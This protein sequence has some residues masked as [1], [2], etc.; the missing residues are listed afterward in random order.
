MLAE[1]GS[2]TFVP[3]ILD[4][5]ASALGRYESV[6][7]AVNDPLERSLVITYLLGAL[8]SEAGAIAACM[9]SA[10]LLESIEPRTLLEQCLQANPAVAQAQREAIIAELARRGW[11]EASAAR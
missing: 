6:R 3:E 10:P 7:G 5:L 8:C 1:D 2:I 11:R 4:L 9:E